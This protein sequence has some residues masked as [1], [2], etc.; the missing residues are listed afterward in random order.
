VLV[1]ADAS[2]AVVDREGMNVAE[3]SAIKGEGGRVQDYPR[4]RKLERNALIDVECEIRILAARSDVIRADNI[5]RL[6]TRMVIGHGNH[7][8]GTIAAIDNDIDVVGVAA[9]ATL[10]A[11][12]V[13]DNGG[14]GL[15]S[16]V[17]AGVDH[18][19]RH[20]WA[21]DVAN[22]SLGARGHWDSLHDAV[23]NT[24]GKG[25]RFAIAAGNDG[26]FAGDYEP[27]RVEHP[28]STHRR[29]H[30]AHRTGSG[31]NRQTF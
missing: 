6:R 17:I 26:A 30:R 18:V 9:G 5:E 4:R 29:F 22:M 31:C 8:A 20:G 7:V 12:R 14:S 11:V 16:W 27:S 28:T 23:R 19:A 25:I 10:C 24:A 15:I 3:L 21:D 13:L 2:G 1:A